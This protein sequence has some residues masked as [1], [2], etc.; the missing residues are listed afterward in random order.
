MS[1][2]E[3]KDFVE[4]NPEDLGPMMLEYRKKNGLTQKDLGKK[5]CISQNTVSRIERGMVS[6][7]SIS[8]YSS[9]YLTYL[10]IKCM[11]TDESNSMSGA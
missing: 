4:V 5:L 9:R 3:C 1:Q 7:A 6:D 2:K 11:E 8:T 10:L